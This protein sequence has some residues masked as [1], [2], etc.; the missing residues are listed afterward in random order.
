[1][2][3]GD[4]FGVFYLPDNLKTLEVTGTAPSKQGAKCYVYRVSGVGNLDG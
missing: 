2:T 4:T 1:M 3:A